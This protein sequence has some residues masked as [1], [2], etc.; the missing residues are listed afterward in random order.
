MSRL[1]RFS[2]HPSAMVV[3]ML[4]GLSVAPSVSLGQ[5]ALPVSS[6]LP[7][8][9]QQPHPLDPALQMTVQS[10]QHIQTHVNDYTALFVKRCRV[11]GVLPPLQYANVKIRNRKTVN[12]QIT[13][14]MGVY[15][16]FLKP[17]AV[18][19]REVVWVEG[20]NDGKLIAHETGYKG[21]V[22]VS[23][24][25]NGYL[26]MR[27]QKRAIN[28]IG[29][30]NLAQKVLET[31]QRDRQY[32]ECQVQFYKNA[33]LGKNDCTM[34]EVI[35]PVRRTHFDFYRA[36]VYFDNSLR[37]PVRYESWSWPETPGGE[38]V[39]EE[40]Y[41]Y[42]RIAVNVGLTDLDFDIS[43]PDYNFR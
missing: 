8:Q 1:T 37:M 29:I 16:N 24:D 36:R 22:N 13:T 20:K 9:S 28:E 38:P 10:L 19:G 18:K 5:Q 25:P 34:L 31:G 27:G 32:E 6:I 17:D 42:V 33:K 7:R 2:F 3:F 23:L 15:L 12:G 26:A 4:I 30:E 14:P 40:E 11:D 35:H 41:T 21:I 43:N 39:L